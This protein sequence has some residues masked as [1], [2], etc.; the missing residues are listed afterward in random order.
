VRTKDGWRIRRRSTTFLRKHGGT[1][2]GKQHDPLAD[3]AEG[4]GAER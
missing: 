3:R 1:D 2:S 4:A